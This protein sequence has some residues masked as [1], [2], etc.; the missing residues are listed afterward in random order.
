MTMTCGTAADLFGDDGTVASGRTEKLAAVKRG[1]V[2]VGRILLAAV[3]LVAAAMKLVAIEFEVHSFEHFG[4]APWFMYVIGAMELA[5]GLML[6][7]PSL[8]A[9]GAIGMMPIMVGAAVSHIVA[10]DSITAT[11]PA[12]VVLGLLG[13]FAYVRRSDI[14]G[15]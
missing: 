1:A 11:L 2:F 6:L 7:A 8:A 5:G 3:F 10:G 4:Y 15:R 12:I 13:W 9:V 14:L